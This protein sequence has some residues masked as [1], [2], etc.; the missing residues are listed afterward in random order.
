[1]LCKKNVATEHSL[2]R[3]KIGI[4]KKSHKVR[5]AGA[6]TVTVTVSPC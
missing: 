6:N 3:Y 1:M 5:G 2:L 4:L